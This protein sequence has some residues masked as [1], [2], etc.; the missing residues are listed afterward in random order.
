MG[1]LKR[2]AGET[3][4]YGLGSILPRFLNFLLVTLHTDVFNP[5]EYGVI[6]KLF[7]Y[8]AVV[9]IIFLFGMETAYFRF[10]SKKD[11]DEK[12][13]FNLAQTVVVSISLVIS[14]ILVLFSYQ[15]SDLLLIP[16]HEKLVIM[17]VAIMFIDAVVA[18]PFSRLRLQRK[19][20]KFAIGKLINIAILI[21]LNLYLLKFSGLKPDISFVFIANLV[22]N[23]FYLVLFARILLQWRPAYDRSISPQMFSY[24]YPV[25]LTGLAG[26]TNEMFSR[27]TLDKWL[28]ENFYPS[29]SKESALGIFG[30]CYKFAVLMNLAI[31]AFRY[32]AEP[33]FFSQS[34]EKNS[35][36]L[37][38][39]VNHYFILVCCILLFSVSINLDVLKFFL[40][41]SEYWDGLYIVPILL[42]A[43]L[44]LGV[45]YNFSVWFKLTDRTYYGTLITIGGV[46][47][48]IAGNYFLIPVA[49]Y[50]GSSIATLL[51]YFAMM[52]AC[53]L[54]GQK[55]YPIPYSIGK[56]FSYIV[57]TV[58]LIYLINSLAIADGAIGVVVHLTLAVF[59]VA[60]IFLLKRKDLVRKQA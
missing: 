38:A 13:I 11:A 6:T 46:I 50:F 44:F 5:P 19:P 42:L 56:D 53:Y 17:L 16:G 33:F 30:A 3:V 40:G 49:G 25:M 22:A 43:Y 28:P 10:S 32:A 34:N 52:V 27:I 35:P 51:C 31:Q 12:R 58:V 23:A 24:A 39:K 26:M 47:I 55:Y 7:S 14:I 18:I 21:G 36:Q 60:A 29:I 15:I 54:F 41:Q 37:F 59:Y 8:V 1:K 45:Y 4:L 48:T 57:L 9:N 20:T 2:L